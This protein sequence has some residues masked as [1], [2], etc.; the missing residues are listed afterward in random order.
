M[1]SGKKVTGCY[2]LVSKPSE[3]KDWLMSCVDSNFDV[4][5][6]ERWACMIWGNAGQGKTSVV[7]QMESQPVTFRGKKYSGFEVIDVPIAQAEE[8]GDLT[9][10]PESE[11]EM[12]KDGKLKFFIKEDSIIS[13]LVGDGWMPTGRTRT[14]CAPPDWVPVEEKPGIILFDDAN[15]AGL[16]IMKGI[17]QLLQNYKMTA[18]KIPAGW[19]IVMTGNPDNRHYSVTSQ[20]EAML[21]RLKHITFEA[22]IMEWMGW[23]TDNDL[24]ERGISFLMKYQEM[25]FGPMLTNPRTLSEFFR[26]L[27]KYPEIN[28]STRRKIIRDARS[29]L[30]EDTVITMMTYFQKEMDIRLDVADIFNN[31]D[32]A[33]NELNKLIDCDEPRIDILNLL[34]SRLRAYINSDKYVFKEA[35]VESLERWVLNKHHPKDMANVLCRNIANSDAPNRRKLLTS[36]KLFKIITDCQNYF[37]K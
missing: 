27:K 21:T 16:R 15:R 9:G 6:E 32:Y 4:P 33:E 3:I 17:M 35:D 18:W 36:K 14:R 37:E 24:D 5:D 7:K 25:M 23:A 20:D 13:V 28:S 8:L 12:E 1:S 34:N 31:P 26:M 30:D 2:G 10:L 19:T 22:D 11:I 29:L